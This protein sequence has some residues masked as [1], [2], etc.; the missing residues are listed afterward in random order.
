MSRSGP[1]RSN[2]AENGGKPAKRKKKDY[3]V[4]VPSDDCPVL[5]QRIE[6]GAKKT[7]PSI[8]LTPDLDELMHPM[9]TEDFLETCFRKKAVHIT[10]KKG[11]EDDHAENRVS[12]LCEEMC[13]LEP[14]AILRETSSDN[15][16]LWLRGKGSGS[17][18]DTNKNDCIRSIEVADADTAIAL[19]KTAGHATY[20]RAPPKVEQS[21]V[22]S[23]LRATGLGCGQYDPS[24]E[25]MI[26]M[27]KGEVETFISTDGHVTNW[28]FD[29]QENFTIQLSGTKRWTIQQG[30]IQDPVRGCTPHYAAP[31]AVEAQL[32]AAHLFDRKFRFGFPER[33]VTAR[34]DVVSVDVKPGD[35]FY[36]PAG[37][38]HKVETI[39]PGVSINVSLMAS[40][41]ATVTCRALQQFL[42]KDKRWREP[43]LNNPT[44][45]AVNHLKDL[46]KELP[47]LIQGLER[48]GAEAIIPP[49][50]Q[51]P[52]RFRLAEDDDW[53]N[54]ED[55]KEDG[56][57]DQEENADD[58]ELQE[59]GGEDDKAFEEEENSDADLEDVIDPLEFDNYPSGWN[60]DIE[61]GAK[62]KLLR[63]PLAALH[64]LD[65]IT[66]FYN[67]KQSRQDGIFV[68]NINYCGNEM[69]Q[70]A[71]R[72]LFC[73]NESN[74]VQK[75]Y[76][77]ERREEGASSMDMTVCDSDHL[78]IKFLIYHGYLQLSKAKPAN[79]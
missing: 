38:W 59:D 4:D 29:F 46:L 39:E 22:S 69:H 44:K 23:L 78:H 52:P 31:E 51:Y 67:G 20:C 68:L 8:S 35:V 7:S 50:L 1:K 60:V 9:S 65:E 6:Y 66:N 25:S 12:G 45:N 62:I 32:K 33:G 18:H 74:F 63:N 36:F 3:K 5:I 11:D 30:T 16:F 21:L 58:D 57:E 77:W 13:G 34:G 61:P 43:I 41:Y 53:E 70:S 47:S 72:V 17:N 71:V 79:E 56:K 10:C 28:H 48:H 24:G 26:S 42:H 19:H 49:V 2:K 76:E 64:R 40:N 15:I 27:G 54:V 73:E 14:E 55:E 37:M 75:L